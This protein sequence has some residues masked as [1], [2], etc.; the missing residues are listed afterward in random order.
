MPRTSLGIL[1]EF[2]YGRSIMAD[3]VSGK[4]AVVTGAGRGL[5]QQVAIA[6]AKSGAKVAVVARSANQVEE[7]VGVIR[8]AGGQA[9]GVAADVSNVAAVDEL[10]KRVR[11]ELGPVSILVNAAGIFGPIQLVAESDP[12]RW[13]ETHSINTIGPYLTCRAFASDMLADRW[14]RIIN[15]SSAAAFHTPGPLN[16]AYGTSKVA[17]N[18]FTRHFAAELAGTGVTATV[19]HPGE[20]KTAMWAEIRDESQSLG[21]IATG[22]RDWAANVG[23]TG[24]DDPQKAVD[25]VLE[26]ILAADERMSGKFLWI[27]NGMQTPVASW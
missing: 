5:G 26:I 6:L 8:D 12:A 27:K 16:S 15:F 13:I 11:S 14:G 7:T 21:E 19:I 3:V 10:A 4:V 22:Y 24:G 2:R 25:L 9:I 17:L 18:H 1:G 20:V 23:A